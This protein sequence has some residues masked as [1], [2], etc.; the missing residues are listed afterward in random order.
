[1]KRVL[2]LGG[3][4]MLGNAVAK[5]FLKQPDK[6]LVS[7]TAR[8]ETVFK[9]G[10]G[11][12]SQ[13]SPV[14]ISNSFQKMFDLPAFRDVIAY[15][16]LE[17]DL[18]KVWKMDDHPDYVV[19]C[20][21]VIKPFI[22]ED[23]PHKYKA[24]YVNSVFPHYLSSYAEESGIK[25]IHISTDCVFSGEKGN[26]TE[27]DSHDATDLYGRSKS[28]GEPINCMV[29]RTSIIGEEVHKNASLVEWVKSNRNGEVDGYTNH[30]WNGMTTTQFGEVCE[31]I[32]SEDLYEEDLYHL[33]SP[34]SINKSDLVSLISDKL[35]LK[36]NVLPVEAP[37]TVDRTL[38]TMKGLNSKL[39]IPDL[40]HQLE[41]TVWASITNK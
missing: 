41:N 12:G 24:I 5:V 32:F 21:G 19:N 34:N 15:N 16:A 17:L 22:K 27:V 11:K 37:E 38:S 30:L 40:S 10:S 20:I 33:H 39:D 25:M 35:N 31:K 2:I 29:L 8:P 23:D 4:G 7:I 18:G 26:Y 14:V 36:V 3:T 6:Y 13:D 28:M 9:D 1:M